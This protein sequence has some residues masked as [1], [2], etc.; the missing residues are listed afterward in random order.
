MHLCRERERERERIYLF[1]GFL[2]FIYILIRSININITYDEAWTLRDFVSL[3]FKQIFSFEPA[4]ANNH[5]LNTVLI[6]ILLKFFLILY[7]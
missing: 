7:S 5:L 3:P 4:D 2:V 1:L 6:K